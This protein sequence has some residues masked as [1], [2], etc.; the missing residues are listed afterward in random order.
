[1]SSQTPINPYQAPVAPLVL[2]APVRSGHS[3]MGVASFVLGLASLLCVVAVFAIVTLVAADLQGSSNEVRG[4]VTAM[5][6][7]MLAAVAS[8]C[9]GFVLGIGALIQRTRSRAFGVVGLLINGAFVAVLVA[10]V[11]GAISLSSVID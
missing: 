5:G 1:V 4:P 7:A 11:I 6:F 8:S 3:R 9:A 10:L 2:R